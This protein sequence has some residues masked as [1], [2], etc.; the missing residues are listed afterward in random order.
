M[1]SPLR[2]GVMGAA[3]IAKKFMLP[4]LREA[5]GVRLVAI[6]SRDRRNADELANQYG[7][8]AVEGYRSLILRDDVDAIYM[9][10]PTGLH[11]EWGVAALAAGKH[12]LVE[13]SLAQNI[14]EARELVSVARASGKLLMEN[15]MFVHHPQQEVVRRLIESELGE[16]RLFS[17]FFGFPPLDRENFRYVRR[18]GGGALLDAGGY[19]LRALDVFFPGFKPAVCAAHLEYGDHEV[20]IAGAATLHLT[21][22]EKTFPAQVAFGFDHSYRC[23]IEIWG[24]QGVLKTSRTFTAGPSVVPMVEIDSIRG[25]QSITLP[26]GN[27]F[28]N[29]VEEFVR[30]VVNDDYE[31][32]Y[33]NVLGQANLQDLVRNRASADQVR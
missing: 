24:S 9:P 12:L 13:K 27:H 31:S 7:C 21:R 11:R 16:I 14:S 3:A 1:T 10:L 4:S 23:G 8:D 26:I 25:R 33:L 17:A 20:D 15:Y 6:A 19:V 22:A 30:R 5:D 18:L 32:E 2:F 28:V 29:L